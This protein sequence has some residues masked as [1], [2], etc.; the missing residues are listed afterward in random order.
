MVQLFNLLWDL[1]EYVSDSF[2]RSYNL[3]SEP[4]EKCSMIAIT[5]NWTSLI[6]VT[7]CICISLKLS[8]C[9]LLS[10]TETP[11][12]GFPI[13]WRRQWWIHNKTGNVWYCWCH[14]P[15][16]CKYN[17]HSKYQFTRKHRGL[18]CIYRKCSTLKLF[19]IL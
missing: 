16:G 2:R 8:F 1:V 3:Y 17:I 14:I 12:R 5:I 4:I 10:L 6:G 18:I 19:S 11:K 9:F 7:S 15:D 13:V